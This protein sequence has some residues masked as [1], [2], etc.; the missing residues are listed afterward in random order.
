M[1]DH[2]QTTGRK[3]RVLSLAILAGLAG[4]R[5][6]LPAFQ[7]QDSQKSE[8]GDLGKEK[9]AKAFPPKATYSPYAGRTSHPAVLRRHP[10]S[11]KSLWRATCSAGLSTTVFPHAR[12]GATFHACISNGKFHGIT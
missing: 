5:L 4:G 6:L 11:H 9:A 8:I 12:A 7:A 1:L 3:S 2:N 10:P